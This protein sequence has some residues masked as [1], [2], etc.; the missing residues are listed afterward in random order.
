MLPPA[1]DGTIDT[2][3]IH[4]EDRRKETRCNR[5]RTSGHPSPLRC[6][7]T[8]TAALALR[9]ITG[10]C[11]GIRRQ[12]QVRR[13]PLPRQLRLLCKLF[14]ANTNFTVCMHIV[15]MP[16]CHSIVVRLDNF[17]FNVF[18]LIEYPNNREFSK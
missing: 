5:V 14:H 2:G 11:T 15:R 9:P 7:I 13:L 3:I 17:N 4:R 8:V 10:F 16:M 18:T 1:V 12:S 6:T